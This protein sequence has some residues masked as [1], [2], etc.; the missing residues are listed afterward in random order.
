MY[1]ILLNLVYDLLNAYFETDHR[2]G[3]IYILTHEV[4]VENNKTL[5]N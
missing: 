3:L 5:F 1:K 2:N 4:E